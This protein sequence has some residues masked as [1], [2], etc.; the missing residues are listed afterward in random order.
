MGEGHALQM[1]IQC[2]I[3]LLIVESIDYVKRCIKM[4]NSFPVQL[5]AIAEG[6][7]DWV[8]LRMAILRV[9]FQHVI[10]LIESPK[11]ME[12]IG[13]EFSIYL[14]G[15]QKRR[16]SHVIHPVE[17]MFFGSMIWR[18]LSGWLVTLQPNAVSGVGGVSMRNSI[19]SRR[20]RDAGGE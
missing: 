13:F 2:R 9:Q 1:N 14:Q 19:G 17:S 16:A 10:L 11:E 3:F 5:L 12:W 4:F 15:S 20:R 18:I 7:V 6:L 8:G